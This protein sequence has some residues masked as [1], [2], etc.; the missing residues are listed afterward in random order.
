MVRKDHS[1]MIYRTLPEKWDAVV[2]EIKELHAKGQPVLVGTVSVENS[3]LVADQLEEDRRSAQRAE[4]EISRARSRD[5][6]TGRTQRRG[7]DRDQHGRPRYRHSARRQSRIS[8]S[9]ISEAA[10]DQS[11]RSDARTVRSR[12]SKRQNASSPRSTKKSSPRAVCTFSAPS[13]TNRAA[14]TTSF[15]DAP[16]VRAIRDRRVSFSR[17]KTI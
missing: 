3:E 11:G 8:G 17:S 16:V 5:R 13:V 12:A 9:R 14:S 4:R 1:D 7:H 15:A 2:E 10:G 6:R